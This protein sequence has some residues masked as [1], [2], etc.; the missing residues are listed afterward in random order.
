[1]ADEIQIIGAAMPRSTQGRGSGEPGCGTDKTQ[2]QTHVSGRKLASMHTQKRRGA[3]I[4]LRW[5]P[6]RDQSGGETGLFPRRIAYFLILVPHRI[7]YLAR[8]RLLTKIESKRGFAL[9]W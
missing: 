9:N 7:C 4:T 3:E 5:T 2:Q 8:R 6:V 1:M